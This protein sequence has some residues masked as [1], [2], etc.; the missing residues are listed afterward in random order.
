VN[1]KPLWTGLAICLPVWGI[2]AGFVLDNAG[3][4]LLSFFAFLLVLW[5]TFPARYSRAVERDR[6]MDSKRRRLP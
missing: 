2:F 1:T 6:F 4:I 5:A 3:L